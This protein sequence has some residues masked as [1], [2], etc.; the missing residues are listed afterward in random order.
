MAGLYLSLW[1]V[2]WLE[3]LPGT[4]TPSVRMRKEPLIYGMSHEEPRDDPQLGNQRNKLIIQA[5]RQL[6]TAK[7]IRYDEVHNAFVVS[8]LG[9]I[10][11]K[12][13]LKYQTIEIFSK[14]ATAFGR[15][16]ADWPDE[17]FH[18][19]MKNADMFAMLSQSTEF[20][21]IQVRDNEIE[22]LTAILQSDHCPMEVKVGWCCW[23]LLTVGRCHQ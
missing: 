5:A 18:P 9:R 3:T 7:M 2:A 8:D 21:Q 13:Y 17:L 19:K 12:Y 20:D 4:L 15:R 6:A 23:A 16:L 1:S 10:A 11:A 14:S 22:E